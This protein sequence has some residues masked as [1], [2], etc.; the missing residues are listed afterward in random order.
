[1]YISAQVFQ[2]PSK[3]V[4]SPSRHAQSDDVIR[5]FM[6]FVRLSHSDVRILL[7]LGSVRPGADP[8]THPLAS[9]S[10]SPLNVEVLRAPLSR[11]CKLLRFSH[12]I[13]RIFNEVL[14]KEYCSLGCDVVPSGRILPTFGRNILP[15]SSGS[16]TKPSKQPDYSST[17]TTEAL[18]SSEMWVKLYTS[19]CRNVTFIVTALRN[20]NII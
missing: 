3:S 9:P 19:H 5:S 1:M 12:A 7:F 16:K 20:P 13:Y 11:F 4:L 18:R 17:L 6:I 8:F 2:P 15:S 10:P 14:I